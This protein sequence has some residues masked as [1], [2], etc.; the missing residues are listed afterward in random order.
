MGA[1]RRGRVYSLTRSIVPMIEA[2]SEV[3]LYRRLN[4]PPPQR[5]ELHEA[6][7]REMADHELEPAD[8]GRQC[9]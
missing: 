5:L 1:I 9:S 2:C 4:D 8:G 3:E 7:L 6:F